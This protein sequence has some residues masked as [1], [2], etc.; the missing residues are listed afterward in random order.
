MMY[1][2]RM[3]KHFDCINRVIDAGK[4]LTLS[5]QKRRFIKKLH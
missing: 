1:S 4:Y 3:H 5:N 2:F